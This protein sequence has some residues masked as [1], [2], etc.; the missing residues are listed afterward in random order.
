MHAIYCPEARTT[1]ADNKPAEMTTCHKLPFST[2]VG[3]ALSAAHE[4]RG[5]RASRRLLGTFGPLHISSM[6]TIERAGQLAES[7]PRR[8]R[9]T[10]R[11]SYACMHKP[12]QT[13]TARYMHGQ[14]R[15]RYGPAGT[16]VAETLCVA[17]CRRAMRDSISGAQGSGHWCGIHPGS[18]GA[19][20][21]RLRT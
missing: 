6:Q 17:T 4:T 15:A 1:V 8:S 5:R 3:W 14:L 9:S 2:G 19:I 16:L 20:P 13:L 12:A 18:A 7:A 10:G 21:T 11:P